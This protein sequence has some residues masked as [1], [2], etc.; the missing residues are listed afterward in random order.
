MSWPGT[1]ILFIVQDL[2]LQLFVRQLQVFADSP[3]DKDDYTAQ[4]SSLQSLH[5]GY[6]VHVFCER[7]SIADQ[8][9]WLFKLTALFSKT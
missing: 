9:P 7:M 5:S 4:S 3:N 6:A 1:A 2:L 8:I